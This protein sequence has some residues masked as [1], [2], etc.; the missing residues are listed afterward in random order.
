M[1]ERRNWW[2]QVHRP[3][4]IYNGT[5]AQR[6]TLITRTVFSDMLSVETSATVTA[7]LDSASIDRARAQVGAAAISHQRARQYHRCRH[8]VTRVYVSNLKNNI[9][10]TKLRSIF[11]WIISLHMCSSDQTMWCLVFVSCFIT[12]YFRVTR[13]SL[14]SFSQL[15]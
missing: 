9:D 14:D 4:F 6:G 11:I 7:V 8:R 5:G 10:S 1:K 12:N 15:H 2:S 3:A 13:M